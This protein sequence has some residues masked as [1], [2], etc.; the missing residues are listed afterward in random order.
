M[1]VDAEKAKQWQEKQIR[2][3]LD[4]RK[5]ESMGVR[6][7]DLMT[8]NKIDVDMQEYIKSSKKLKWLYK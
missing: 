1:Q 5:S 4:L 7:K 2:D 6:L 8:K 3:A